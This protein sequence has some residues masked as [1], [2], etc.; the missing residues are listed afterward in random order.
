MGK[1]GNIPSERKGDGGGRS[2]RGRGEIRKR[3]RS[4]VGN[5]KSLKTG[6]IM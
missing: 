5:G 2:R 1:V 3:G 4:V 6:G